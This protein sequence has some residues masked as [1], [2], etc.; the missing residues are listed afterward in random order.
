MKLEAIGR[1]SA[2]KLTDDDGQVYMSARNIGNSRLVFICG[3]YVVKID[4]TAH[5][6]PTDPR[7]MQ[8]WAEADLFTKLDVSG[9]KHFAAVVD[10]GTVDGRKYVI[11]EKVCGDLLDSLSLDD[12]DYSAIHDELND[13]SETYGVWDLHGGN[14][15]VTPDNEIVV[16][17]YGVNITNWGPKFS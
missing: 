3:P 15:M 16:V 4:S 13:I 12:E 11:Q 6:G 7:S 5:W 9:Q 10:F 17:D 1:F 14:V 8:S 2:V